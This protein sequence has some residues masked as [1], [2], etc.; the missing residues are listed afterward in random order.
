MKADTKY[1]CSFGAIS[2]R[3]LIFT[4]TDQ[5]TPVLS[6]L[7]IHN[8]NDSFT[9]CF[10]SVLTQLVFYQ[11]SL[12]S[13]LSVIQVVGLFAAQFFLPVLAASLFGPNRLLDEVI[14]CVAPGAQSSRTFPLAL[15]AHARYFSTF[16][17]N[18]FLLL[19]H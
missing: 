7:F 16:D 8:T 9:I 17:F 10:K 13:T 15:E 19:P 3:S 11:F 14:H 5:Q 2:R 18:T 4:V 6:S 1:I 12:F